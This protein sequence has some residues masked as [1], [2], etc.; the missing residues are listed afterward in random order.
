MAGIEL[1]GDAPVNVPP[2]RVKGEPFSSPGWRMAFWVGLAVALA[3][4][5]LVG[6]FVYSFD[7]APYASGYVSDEVYYASVAAKL[8]MYV[9]GYGGPAPSVASSISDSYWNFE[10]PPLAKYIMAAS[11][12]LL[13]TPSWISYRAPSIA[14][15]VL[16][17]L[18]IYLAFAWPPGPGKEGVARATAGAVAAT[19][20]PLE[21]IVR[22]EGG[23]ALLDPYAAFFALVS[24]ALA[25]RRKYLASAFAAGLA[26][27]SKETALPLA[28]ALPLFYIANEARKP[29]AS[30]R[31]A[32]LMLLL[33]IAIGVIS[34]VPEFVFFGLKTVIY[35]GM[36]LMAHWDLVSRPS[37]PTPS[38]PIDWFVGRNSMALVYT[39][40]NGRTIVVLASMTPAVELPALAIAVYNAVS[41]ALERKRI[42]D[43]PTI[44]FFVQLLGFYAAYLAGNHTLYSMYSIIFVPMT[45]A[46]WGELAYSIIAR[47]TPAPP[48]ARQEAPAAPAAAPAPAP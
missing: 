36:L 25:M 3:A 34:Y 1:D 40:I 5:I 48:Q 29:A 8:A 46:L 28:L 37:G 33:P 27:A 31:K 2:I 42:W 24:L 21:H 7:A 35:N 4:A 6:F 22:V 32:E 26:I 15:A 19:I 13:R 43:A 9:F 41:R 14:M 20:F 39:V 12:A 18:I 30:V 47:L 11:I 16:E 10:H 44:F 23:L 17:P 38:Q 45:A